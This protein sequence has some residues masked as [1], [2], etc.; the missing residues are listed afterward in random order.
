MSTGKKL[1]LYF[2]RHYL[3]NE[4]SNMCLTFFVQ[5]NPAHTES[6]EIEENSLKRS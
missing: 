1:M 5:V 6:G 2:E 3:N 4:K